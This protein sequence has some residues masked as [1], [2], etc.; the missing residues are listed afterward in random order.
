MFTQTGFFQIT[1]SARR[2]PSAG[3]GML[4]TVKAVSLLTILLFAACGEDDSGKSS[5]WQIIGRGISD[6]TVSSLALDLDASGNPIAAYSDDAAG[7]KLTVKIFNGTSWDTAGTAG[8]SGGTVHGVCVDEYGGAIYTAFRDASA[9]GKLSVMKFAGGSWSYVGQQGFTSDTA[10]DL[11]DCW[12]RRIA[13]FVL[14]ESAMYLA[15]KNTAGAMKVW[16]FNGPSWSDISGILP[17]TG[18]EGHVSIHGLTSEA[19]YAAYAMTS[20]HGGYVQKYIGS[21]SSW[22]PAGGS[23]GIFT[24]QDGGRDFVLRV[25][26][27]TPYIALSEVDGDYDTGGDNN[28]EPDRAV[29]RRLNGT[30]WETVGGPVSVSTATELSLG[31]GP[32]G[33]PLVSYMDWDGI[34]SPTVHRYNGTEWAL[35][36]KCISDTGTHFVKMAVYY[37]KP[38]V[39]FIESEGAYQGNL[40]V[41]RY[42]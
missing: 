12:N 32:N 41:M 39:A 25:H 34:A 40:T 17:L 28:S 14:S 13:F 29:V 30:V 6:G 37:D 21:L 27:G 7:G 9:A 11:N 10:E 19:I 16:L 36:G 31:F 35:L 42:K 8:A 5:P 24:G 20:G 2:A 4:L 18:V 26:G 3:K 23:G 15:Y 38:V 22:G 1:A 33:N